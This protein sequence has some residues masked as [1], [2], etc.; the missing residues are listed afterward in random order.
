MKYYKFTSILWVIML[1]S[2]SQEDSVQYTEPDS[3]KA[4]SSIDLYIKEKLTDPYNCRVIY[5]FQ[6]PL[7]VED[8]DFAVTPPRQEVVIP[9]VD[10]ILTY[11][12]NPI[13]KVKNGDPLL[14]TLFPKQFVFIGSTLHRT[15]DGRE[16]AGVAEA[17]I[18]ITLADLN[19]Y[20]PKDSHFI[21]REVHTLYH[22]FT[23]IV[24]QS[25]AEGVPDAYEKVNPKYR[26]DSWVNVK[27]IDAITD[28]FVTPYASKN[29]QEDLAE[30]VSTYLTMSD[31]AFNKKYI[32]HQEDDADV[33]RDR[34]A[35]KLKIAKKYFNQYYKVDLEEIKD[36]LHVELDKL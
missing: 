32:T 28:G 26:G 20:N 21:T 5:S 2:C 11:F 8:F 23:H 30:M 6:Q 22:E 36:S 4:S 18:M 35:K 27:E 15:S 29:P 16:F 25:V 14:K 13:K 34:I 31:K 24:H 7:Y 10:M 33:G 3:S 12:V 1:F 19:A 17:S 9:V